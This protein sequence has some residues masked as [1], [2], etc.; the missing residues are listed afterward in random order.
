M[1]LAL[2]QRIPE[3]TSQI[4]GNHHKQTSIIHP[5]FK[6]ERLGERRLT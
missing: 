6:T 2:F 3:D 4:L 1:G 5:C